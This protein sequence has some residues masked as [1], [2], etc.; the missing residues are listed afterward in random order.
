MPFIVYADLECILEKMETEETSSHKYQY[1]R[2]LSLAYYVYCSYD[3][4][5]CI[6]RFY[7]AKDCVAWLAEEL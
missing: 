2:V 5:L 7:R 1:H 6:Y 4:S 3:A